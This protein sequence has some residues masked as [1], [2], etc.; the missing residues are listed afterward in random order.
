MSKRGKVLLRN[1]YLALLIMLMGLA[2]HH[3]EAGAATPSGVTL[4][5]RMSRAAQSVSY[6]ARQTTWRKN[7]PTIIIQIWDN[8][9]KQR[10]EFVAPPINKGD[11]RLDDGTHIRRY[12]RSENGVVQTPSSAGHVFDTARFSQK[13][14]AR[15][16]GKSKVAGRSAWIVGIQAKNSSRYLRKYW[17]DTSNYLRLRAEYFGDDGKRVEATQ[18]SSIHFGSVPS[19]KFVWKT[20]AGAKVNYAGELYTRLNRALRQATWMRVPRWL[21]SGYAFES[22]VINKTN[23]EIWLRYSNGSHRFSVFEQRTNDQ[24]STSVRKVDGGWFWSK[25]G[26]RY[27]IAGLGEADA[28]K[29]ANSF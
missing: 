29:M 24:K 28:K 22:V 4:L 25:G 15:V 12:H 7:T 17:I 19:S 1:L 9:K 8:G 13:Y 27:F 3:E 11:I 2:G 6:S 10:M 26:M 16:L 14:Q 18:L 23:N 5:T 21:P 20:P